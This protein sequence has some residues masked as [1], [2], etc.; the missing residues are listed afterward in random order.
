M[1][2]SHPQALIPYITEPHPET[3]VTN[4]KLGIWV[5]L[6]SEVML[7]GALFSSYVLIRVGAPTWPDG[8]DVLNVPLATVNTATLIISSVTVV[9]AWAQLKMNNISGAKLFLW[10]TIGCAL[11]FM[12]IKSIEYSAKFSHGHYPATDV[13]YA[14][15]VGSKGVGNSYDFP[16]WPAEHFVY[17]YTVTKK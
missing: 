12:V 10:L 9:M 13:F 5:F 15:A 4:G 2:S 14:F 3:G 6:A 17:P 7:F 8:A 11:I 16:Q 1:A